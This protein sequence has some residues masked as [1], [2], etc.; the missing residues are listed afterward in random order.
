VLESGV[1]VVS[2]GRKVLLAGLQTRTAEAVQEYRH[3]YGLFKG[4]DAGQAE[5]S[6][7]R[8]LQRRQKP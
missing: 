1:V 7:V 6:Q 8:V 5:R 2:V 3:R 4:G